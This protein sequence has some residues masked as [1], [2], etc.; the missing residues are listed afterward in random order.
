MKNLTKLFASLA[1]FFAMV[2]VFTIPA[3]ANIHNGPLGPCTNSGVTHAHG[4]MVISFGVG[5]HVTPSNAQCSVTQFV[6]NHIVSCSVCTHRLGSATLTCRE[7][8]NSSHC[9]FFGTRKI[10]SR[11]N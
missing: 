10:D 8:H 5:S 3:L 2:M 4:M 6:H 11:C 7:N 1:L 9:G